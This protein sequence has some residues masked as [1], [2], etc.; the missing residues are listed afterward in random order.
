[1]SGK[2]VMGVFAFDDFDFDSVSHEAVA[3]LLQPFASS[4]E[5]QCGYFA[6]G[7][8]SVGHSFLSMAEH[9]VIGE[10]LRTALG[11]TKRFTR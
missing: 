6:G 5:A 2:Q 9:D 7:W 1:M 3:G 4:H 11:R 8:N 10:H